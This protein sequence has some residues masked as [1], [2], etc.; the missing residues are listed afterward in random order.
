MWETFTTLEPFQPAF[1]HL[2]METS[3]LPLPGALSM[4]TDML[5]EP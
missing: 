1:A 4:N 5:A 2:K 3:P